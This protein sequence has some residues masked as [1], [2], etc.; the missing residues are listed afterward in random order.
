MP[1]DQVNAA[2]GDQNTDGAEHVD[3]D[4][5]N[6]NSPK[7]F[8]E[9]EV[10]N[11][12]KTRVTRL[13]KS[14][15]DEIL[16]DLKREADLADA[17]KNG[18]W[19]KLSRDKD[20]QISSLSSKASLVDQYE[21][22]ANLRWVEMKKTLP[23]A[24]VILAP[25][26]ESPAIER[27]RWYTTKALPAMEKLKKSDATKGNAPNDPDT[28]KPTQTDRFNQLVEEQNRSGQYRRLV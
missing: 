14:L 20:D 16:A 11:I 27:E 5:K 23:E 13:R 21:E 12:V 24:L 4:G 15:R 18:E 28:K 26:D 10:E 25:D 22:M 3:P 1:D 17:A 2:D 9:P 19:E 8:S 6:G 7:T